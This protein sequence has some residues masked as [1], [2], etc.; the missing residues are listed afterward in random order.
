[1]RL[2]RR[3]VLAYTISSLC[4]NIEELYLYTQLAAYALNRRIGIILENT[5]NIIMIIHKVN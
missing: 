1:M 2:N 3:I 4:V 5:I